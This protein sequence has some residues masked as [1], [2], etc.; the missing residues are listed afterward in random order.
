MLSV[1]PEN[2]S[3]IFCCFFFLLPLADIPTFF[4]MFVLSLRLFKQVAAQQCTWLP[5]KQP[6]F[7]SSAI[8]FPLW[9]EWAIYSCLCKIPVIYHSIR[10]TNVNSEFPFQ[11]TPQTEIQT[12]S[13][14]C[15]IWMQSHVLLWFWSKRHTLDWRTHLHSLF[16][17]VTRR[18][19]TTLGRCAHTPHGIARLRFRWNEKRIHFIFRL[20][21]EK[22]WC[23]FFHCRCVCAAHV[24]LLIHT[25]ETVTLARRKRKNRLELKCLQ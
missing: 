16:S 14:P 18:R 17:C 4:V 15:T 25:T 21:L 2:N 20:F 10:I 23:R 11:Y 19:H 12:Q 9:L 13:I 6:F 24:F 8:V 7:S 22:W 3:C 1:D 5:H